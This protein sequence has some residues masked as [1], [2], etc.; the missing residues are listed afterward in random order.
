VAVGMDNV[1]VGYQAV[2]H[3]YGLGHR[4]IL[5]Y[6][7]GRDLM[8]GE[9]RF[10]GFCKAKDE[11]GLG[12]TLEYR[13]DAH[14]EDG[15]YLS[16]KDRLNEPDI[17]TAIFTE[18]EIGALGAERALKEAGLRVPED[19]SVMTC[20]NARFMRLVAPHLTVLNVRQIEV[21]SEAGHLMAKMLRGDEVEKRQRYLP[22]ILE[23]R[24][25]TAPP[26]RR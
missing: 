22:P 6:N 17:P 4:R 16:L 10:Q 20:L 3:L 24:A 8:S 5:F 13:D 21:A 25:S 26:G 2:E 15:I 1:A 18:D 14:Y 19:I 12:A 9:R 11:F 23:K 7:I